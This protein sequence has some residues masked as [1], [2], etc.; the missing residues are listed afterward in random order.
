M[1]YLPTVFL[2]ALLLLGTGAASAASK[3][4]AALPSQT[5]IYAR[6]VIVQLK[7]SA[8]KSA[9]AV[10]SAKGVSSVVSLPLS[11]R[12]YQVVAVPATQDYAATLS[13]LRADPS[14]AGA[15]PNVIKHA[16]EFIPNDPFFLNGATTVAEA[17]QSPRVNNAQWGLLSTGITDAWDATAGSPNTVV[18]VIDTGIS[19]AHE[20]L[21]NRL[22]TNPGEIVGNGLDDDT[23][24]FVDDI[25]GYD[26]QTYNPN[27]QSGGD[28]DPED[29]ES[30]AESHGTACSSIIAGQS[31]NGIG[32]A[33]VAGGKNAN[34]GA[35]IMV[36]RVGTRSVI[37]LSAEIAALD[38]AHE[39]HARVISM[40]FGGAT[41]GQPEEDAVNRAWDSGGSTGA[42]VLAAG[43]NGNAGNPG[44]L[45]DLPAGFDNCVCVGATTIFSNWP[46]TT[47]T[48]LVPE[49][50]ADFSKVGPEMDIS[51][52]GVHIISAASGT[53][54]YM[55]TPFSQFTGTSAATPV[56]AGLAALLFSAKPSLTPLQ[57]REILYNTADDLGQAG[58]DT[59]FGHGRIDMKAALEAV[60]GNGKQ[61]DTDGDGVVDD[62]DAQPIID[63]FG[64]RTGDPSYSAAIDA[65]ADGVIDELDLFVIGRKFG[66]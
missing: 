19:F 33:G 7:P 63:N 23:N 44:G 10:W 20:D 57:T 54:S 34:D 14:V 36:L 45:I 11:Y 6:Q 18:A 25:H 53:D 43:G 47:S 46:V 1:R 3:N 58:F 31:N 41:G 38:Y 61:G 17:L 50:R 22:W 55:N 8:A 42:L 26:F 49:E 62:N 52:P 35:R 2:L 66:S 60:A 4:V 40:S 5:D 30:G 37:P 32:L 59:S 16:S 65:N 21:K 13:A 48:L 27:D 56:V 24:G 64:S 12:T 28:A 15:W 51:A 39:N 9:S 29:T